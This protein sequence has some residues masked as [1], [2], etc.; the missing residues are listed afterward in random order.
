MQGV[1][2][3]GRPILVTEVARKLA[4]VR[5]EDPL[6]LQLCL[7]SLSQKSPTLPTPAVNEFTVERDDVIVEM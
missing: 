2:V 3:M 5:V 7:G 6:N 4:G 1:A